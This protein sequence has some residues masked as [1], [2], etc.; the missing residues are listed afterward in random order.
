MTQQGDL[1]LDQYWFRHLAQG[2]FS[3][4]LLDRMLE[5]RITEILLH[6]PEA[7]EY[8]LSGHHSVFDWLCLMSFISIHFL[9]LNSF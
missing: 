9:T 1:D 5:T 3:E 7:N 4:T 6:L 8:L 2:N